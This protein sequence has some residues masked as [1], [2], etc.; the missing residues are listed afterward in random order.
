M[1]KSPS[2]SVEAMTI[3][4]AA[5]VLSPPTHAQ[6]D[7]EAPPLNPSPVASSSAPTASKEVIG[8]NPDSKF[9][10]SLSGS[11]LPSS[12]TKAEYS[13]DPEKFLARVQRMRTFLPEKSFASVVHRDPPPTVRSDDSA[14][15]SI[16]APLR[17]RKRRSSSSSSEESSSKPVGSRTS[18]V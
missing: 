10:Q 3:D 6:S 13:A 2:D 8:F 9:W 1:V 11:K 15:F 18:P 16:L 17:S 5:A 14:N 4:E 12:A 7:L